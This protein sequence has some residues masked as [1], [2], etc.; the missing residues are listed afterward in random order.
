MGLHAET[1]VIE[2]VAAAQGRAV[3]FDKV[4]PANQPNRLIFGSWPHVNKLVRIV[5]VAATADVGQIELR[6]I[7]LAERLHDA[8]HAFNHILAFVLD[9]LVDG[10]DVVARR[11]NARYPRCVVIGA[12]ITAIDGDRVGTVVMFVGIGVAHTDGSAIKVAR[13]LDVSCD[14]SIVHS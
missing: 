2:T 10:I 9:N 14:A 11:A 5:K 8:E 3:A 1:V 13:E 7:I 6:Q 12:E 4:I